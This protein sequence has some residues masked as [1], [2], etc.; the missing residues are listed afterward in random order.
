MLFLSI[1]FLSC[2]LVF[3]F[4][5]Y[6]CK[7]KKPLKRAF[8]S[9]LS[10]PV[11]LVILNILSSVTGVYIPLSQLS[12]AVSLVFGLPGVALLTLMQIL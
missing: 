6:L 2:V 12:F 3:C 9:V 7:I 8:C 11:V 4:I 5:H 1:V 10:G